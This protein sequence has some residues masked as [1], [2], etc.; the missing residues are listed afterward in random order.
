[1]IPGLRRLRVRLTIWYIGVFAVVLLLFAVAI[2]AVV[3]HQISTK[4]D[5][6]LEQAVVALEE[7]TAIEQREQLLGPG[8]V[9]ALDEL[10]IPDRS[11]YLFDATGV[12][13]HPDTAADFIVAAAGRA[14]RG[15]APV[16][17][18]VDLENGGTSRIRARTFEL[19]GGG[20]RIGVAA[21]LA[22]EIDHEYPG[23]LAGFAAAALVA[24]LAAG[25]AAS[26]SAPA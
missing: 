20:T 24:L 16:T 11:I 10:R 4:L 15:G 26:R 6:S 14:L 5:R 9:D 22:P 7:A 25:V 2:L 13:V 8:R 17:F 18:E 23:L 19:A 21:A 3:E 12:L 1:M